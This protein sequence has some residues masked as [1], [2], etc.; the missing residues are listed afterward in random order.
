MKKLSDVTKLNLFVFFTM[1]A[2]FSVELF[3]PVILYKLNFSIQE[4]LIFLLYSYVLNIISS[5]PI[6]K[7]GKKYGF[8]YIVIASSFLFTSFYFVVSFMKKNILYFIIVGFLNSVSNILYYIGRHNYAGVVLNRNKIGKGVGGIIISTVF[9]SMVASLFSSY[10]IEKFSLILVA[11]II[12][13]IYLLGTAFIFKIKENQ[14]NQKISLK[15]IH[16][17]ISKS[18]KLFFL[19]EQFKTVFFSLY[20]LYVYIFVDNTY[21]YIGYIY[22]ITSIASII[23]I[24]FYSKKIDKKN[25]NFLKISAILLSTIL[26][27]DM[28]ISSKFWALVVVFIEG[29]CIKFY[30]TSVAKNMYTLKGKMEGSSYFLYME[31]LYNIGRIIIVNSILLFSLKIRTILFICILFIF[32]S[33]FI[34]FDLE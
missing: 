6:T 16:N 3:M 31:I 17:N 4:I 8:K 9:A 2:K 12:T 13:I 14:E 30:E 15:D 26:F 19:I 11:I 5:I 25:I 32:I 28:Y 23:F 21:T 20:P 18:N 24:Y 34:K 22:L 33:G 27:I 1:F 7:V 10:V 29:I